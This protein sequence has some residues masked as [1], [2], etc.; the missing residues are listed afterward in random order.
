MNKIKGLV[1]ISRFEYLE[2]KYGTEK[3]SN[4][5]SE[6]STEEVNFKRQPVD[7]ASNYPESALTLIDNLIL[8]QFF[9]GDVSRFRAMGEWD[10]ERFMPRLFNHYIDLKEPKEF[11]KQYE[12]LRG[13]LIGSGEMTV[14]EPEAERITIKIDYGQHIPRSVCL[15]E[16]GFISGGMQLCGAKNVQITEHS[17]AGEEPGF[18]CS[19]TISFKI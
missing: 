12:R 19:Y 10:A 11:L 18:E 16:Q 3:Y 9:E 7:A 17:C 1:I 4:F 5:L 2:S 6:I 13:Y 8:E 14:T 15:S